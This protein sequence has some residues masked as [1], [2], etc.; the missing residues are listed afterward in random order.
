MIMIISR[1]TQGPI[2]LLGR[3]FIEQK[4]AYEDT[5][6]RSQKL[7]KEKNVKDSTGIDLGGKRN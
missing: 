6:K 4:N 7:P 1:K 3:S 5:N 2:R